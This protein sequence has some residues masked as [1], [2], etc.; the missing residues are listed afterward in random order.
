MLLVKEVQVKIRYV[1]KMFF[2]TIPAEN[3]KLKVNIATSEAKTWHERFGHINLDTISKISKSGAVHGMPQIKKADIGCEACCLGK[4]HKTSLKVV[5]EEDKATYNVV[6]FFYSD[7]CDSMQ[8]E[9][10]G[11]ARYVSTFID[12]A[13][14]VLFEAQIR[15]FQKIQNFRKILMAKFRDVMLALRT[16]RG[17]E[18]VCGKMEE[19]MP[20]LGIRHEPTAPGTPE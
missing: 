11:G 13:H 2:Q 18:Y 9:S 17:R 3:P 1:Y 4:S 20:R 8:I 5:A 15:R 19:Y 16:D 6:E 7:V 10:I 12:S 14:C